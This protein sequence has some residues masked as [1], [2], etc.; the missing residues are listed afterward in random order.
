M[1]FMLLVF[2]AHPS[3]RCTIEISLNGVTAK[4]KNDV[5]LHFNHSTTEAKVAGVEYISSKN[6]VDERKNYE[7][8]G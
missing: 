6:N 5:Q 7:S 4:E 3:F 8:Q 1:L 2:H